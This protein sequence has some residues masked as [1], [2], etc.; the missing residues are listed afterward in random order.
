MK[1]GWAIVLSFIAAVA[2]SFWYDARVAS[3][4][5]TTAALPA[6]NR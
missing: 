1:S 6:A 2:G 4:A 3:H 5:A